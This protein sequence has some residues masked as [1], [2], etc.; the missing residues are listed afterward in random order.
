MSVRY[1]VAAMNV[2]A[3]AVCT[4]VVAPAVSGSGAFFGER[5]PVSARRVAALPVLVIGLLPFGAGSM[6]H[7]RV[8]KVVL[9]LAA[10]Q[11]MISA[12]CQ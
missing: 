2:P 8:W 4:V 7:S 12:L 11:D 1:G 9:G 3:V 10:T 6:F 5:L